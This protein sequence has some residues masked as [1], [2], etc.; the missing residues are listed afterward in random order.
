MG[1][2]RFPER[3][4]KPFRTAAECIDWTLPCPSICARK[5]PLSGPTRQRIDAGLAMFPDDP[6]LIAYFGSEDGA[7]S[8]ALPLRT[9]TTK[10][11]FA[12]IHRRGDDIGMRMLQPRELFR[13]QGFG[14]DYVIEHGVDETGGRIAMTKTQQVKACGNSVCPPVVAALVRANLTPPASGVKPRPVV[15]PAEVRA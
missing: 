6:F 4:L 7:Q 10:D 8:I 5:R 13:A 12:L 2:G 11:R 15:A 3:N 14:D 9:I 1:D